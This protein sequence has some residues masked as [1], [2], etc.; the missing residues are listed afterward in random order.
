ME[1]NTKVGST[2][3]IIIYVDNK[4]MEHTDKEHIDMLVAT[5]N[6]KNTIK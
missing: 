4:I 6:E 2:L 1:G 3:N 5:E